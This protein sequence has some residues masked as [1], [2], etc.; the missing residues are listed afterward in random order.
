MEGHTPVSEITIHSTVFLARRAPPEPGGPGGPGEGL[1]SPSPHQHIQEKGWNG[2][3]MRG[4]K[5]VFFWVGVNRGL[6][7]FWGVRFRGGMGSP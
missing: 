2:V 1:D 4:F 7:E 6:V 3:R 5:G